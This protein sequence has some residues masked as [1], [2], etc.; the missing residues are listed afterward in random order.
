MNRR[1]LF[2]NAV[3]FCSMLLPRPTL[4][5]GTIADYQRAAAV[6]E[7]LQGLAVNMP[8][9][10]NWIEGTRRVWY[11]NSVKGG[12]QSVLVDVADLLKRPAFDHEKL[13][14]SLAAGSAEKYSGV[15]LPF[16]FITFVDN[17]KSLEFAAGDSKWRCD[18]T[19]YNCKEIGPAGP[20]DL[21][22]G[23]GSSPPLRGS[24]EDD[25][26]KASPDGK[27]EA[28]VKNYNVHVRAKGSKDTVPLSFDGSEGNYYTPAS[29]RWSPESPRRGVYRERPGYHR[30]IQYIESSPE[31][32]LQPK[33]STREYV[34]PGDALDIRQPV[35]FQVETRKQ[36][37]VENTLFPNPYELSP[38]TWRK[39]SRAVT[40]EYNQRGHQV[41]RVIEVDARTAKARAVISEEAQTFFCYSG[42]KFRHAVAFS[43]DMKY[44]VDTWSRV[45]VPPISQLRRASDKKLLAELERG[46]IQELLRTGWR[47]PEVFTALGRDGKTG[48]WG[49]IVRPTNFDPSRKYPVIENIYA[50]PQDSFVPKSFSINS[51]MQSMAE[52]G[53]IV[54]QID[55][56]GTSNRSKA[57]HDVAWKNLADAGFPD[58]IL[59]HKA[60]AEKYPY[61]DISRA[62]IYGHSAGGQN[63]LAALLFHPEFYAAAASS[64][65]CHDNRMD[66]IWWNEQWMG[67]PLGPEYAACSNVEKASKLQG[68]LLLSVGE[69]DTNVDAASTMQVVNALIKANKTFELLVLPGQ[70]HSAGG[71]YGERKRFDFFV[72]HLLSVEP[73]DWNKI[74]KSKSTASTGSG[75]A[76][77]Q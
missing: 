23:R 18:L 5:Q 57:F 2:C 28:F 7:K 65:G 1:H 29:I 71:D 64:C 47:P 21:R 75:S 41:Y 10:A 42:K 51:G 8:E 20:G 53:F 69:M 67:W 30:K 9:K 25:Q 46:D 31:D 54:V 58:R 43:Q 44:Y 66:K 48:I 56:M 61:Y 26:P 37:L 59:W 15:T 16:S 36:L 50:G 14:A 60:V 55:G 40:F 76:Q 39:D 52:L 27:W 49:I 33:Y 74:E 12:N 32:Q 11:R 17:E 63:A 62:G 3:L 22:G 45:D 13:A 24:Q 4:A 35:L 19:E 72:H 34:K 73:P 38:L 70:G 6:R 68:K 77:P